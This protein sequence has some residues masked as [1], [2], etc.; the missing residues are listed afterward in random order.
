MMA[1][2][3][4]RGQKA[5]PEPPGEDVPADTA[6]EQMRSF[7]GLFWTRH[8]FSGSRC[9]DVARRRGK[10]SRFGLG[11]VF[12]FRVAMRMGLSWSHQ[13]QQTEIPGQGP[14]GLGITRV[15]PTC[16][17]SPRGAYRG[18][19]KRQ[20]L[21]FGRQKAAETEAGLARER[22]TAFP[23]TGAGMQGI[24]L[25][26]WGMTRHEPIDHWAYPYFHTPTAASHCHL[27][28]PPSG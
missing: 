19:H 18:D 26:I 6:S 5:R 15:F 3:C 12:G 28:P 11:H 16:P 1:G 25:C 21:H 14:R 20:I 23:C 8:R 17:H 10:S 13:A 2:P 24:H 27:L 22:D 4:R 9:W 7:A